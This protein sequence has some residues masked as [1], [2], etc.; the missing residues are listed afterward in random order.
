V[1]AAL[2]WIWL[3]ERTGATTWLASTLAFVGVLVTLGG[4]GFGTNL[5]GDLLAFTMT[6][7]VA[8]A[9]VICRRHRDIP[10]VPAAALSILFGSI[11]S[12]PWAAPA[13]AG[14]TDLAYLALFGLFQMT[15]GLTLFTIGAP[16][17]PAAHTALIGALEAPLAPL[18][19]WIA[20]GELAAAT[21]LRRRRH[22]DARR[23]RP[24]SDREPPQCGAH[25]RPH[26]GQRRIAPCAWSPGTATWRCIASWRR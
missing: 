25:A 19:V 5:W 2:A 7:A 12:L 10:M 22:R 14:P 6:V 18:W 1:T 16:L 8:V 9:M 13:A 24:H 23:G 4:S 17:I 11:V 20:F 21:G 26:R 15:L 3:R